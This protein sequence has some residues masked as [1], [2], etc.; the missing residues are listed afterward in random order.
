MGNALIVISG[1]RR[2]AYP[3]ESITVRTNL[4]PGRLSY[5]TEDGWLGVQL[6]GEQRVDEYPIEQ[7]AS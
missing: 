6:D 1:G 4:G 3:L 7:V 2:R 5:L